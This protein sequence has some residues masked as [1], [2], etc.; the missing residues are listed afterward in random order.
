MKICENVMRGSKTVAL[1]QEI[2]NVPLVMYSLAIMA[3]PDA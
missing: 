3:L 2:R 1:H